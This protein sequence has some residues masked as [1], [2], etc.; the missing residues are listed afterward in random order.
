MFPVDLCWVCKCLKSEWAMIGQEVFS[1]S[2]DQFFR[3]ASL[4]LLCLSSCLQNYRKSLSAY[5]EAIKRKKKSHLCCRCSLLNS[6]QKEMLFLP[7][8]VANKF[9]SGS[10]KERARLNGSI[11]WAVDK[12]KQRQHLKSHE[13][14]WWDVFT[15]LYW[16]KQ[17]VS[18]IYLFI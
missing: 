18:L 12:N 15:R 11:L 2:S 7:F 8:R 5:Q 4:F 3:S 1:R 9:L 17:S 6:V 16:I 13:D 10:I 14:S